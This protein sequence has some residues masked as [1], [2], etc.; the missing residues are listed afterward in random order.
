MPSPFNPKVQIISY[1]SRPTARTFV[2]HG[3][4]P[5]EKMD[6]FS[7]KKNMQL[8]EGGLVNVNHF[9]TPPI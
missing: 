8:L 2:L 5:Q 7:V 9:T 1:Q 6:F 4:P 3:V